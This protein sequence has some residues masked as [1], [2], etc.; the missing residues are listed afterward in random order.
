MS[1]ARSLILSRLGRKAQSTVR[2]VSSAETPG[3]NTGPVAQFAEQA[4][5]FG[6]TVEAV[7]DL[8]GLCPAVTGYLDG[9]AAE[10]VVLAPD[11]PSSYAGAL[12]NLE[13][14]IPADQQADWGTDGVTIIGSCAAGVAE[15]GTVMITS[16]HNADPRLHYLAETQI[17]VLPV[18]RIVGTYE[19]AWMLWQQEAGGVLPR[20]VSFITGPSRT[21]DI[22]QTIE[23]GA[24]GP[25]RLHILLVG[26]KP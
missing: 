22:E 15:T 25:R 18:S 9:I 24:H 1:T 13:R 10:P 19:H 7:K 20:L 17:I 26:E 2:S 5:R 12:S 14:V 11:L 21:A 6:A 4:R 23:R 3:T 16:G 8:Q